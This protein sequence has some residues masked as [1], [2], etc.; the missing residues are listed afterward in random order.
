[1]GVPSTLEDIYR[2]I[3]PELNQVHQTVSTFWTDALRLVHGPD[4]PQ[5]RTGG[6]LLRPALCLLSGGAIGADDLGQLVNLAATFE[7]L[8]FAALVHDDVI[9]SAQLRRGVTSLN[10]LW[11]DHSAVL[12]GDY[13]VSRATALLTTYESCD[14]IASVVESVRRMS[15]GELRAIGRR[16]EHFSEDDCIQL[17]RQKTASLFASTCTGPTYLL[18]AAAYREPLEQYGLGFGI[19]FQLADDLLDLSQSEERLGKPSCGDI[20]EGKTTLPILFMREGMSADEVARLD[21]MAG[22]DIT[23]EDRAWIA[24]ALERTGARRRT[25]ALARLHV[26]E[27][28]AALDTLPPSPYR[29]SMYRLLD[30]C[31]TRGA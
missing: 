2:P 18:G 27:A 12:G 14:L 23:D 29:D 19:A 31:L 21:A 9:D 15:E 17:A 6:K 7:M 30:F 16:P 25:D 8:H 22:P 1:M 11:D 24:D 20:V 5:Q 28:R 3:R 4:I 10:V 26:D 13:L